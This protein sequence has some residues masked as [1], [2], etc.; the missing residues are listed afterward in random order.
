MYYTH[1]FLYMIYIAH[2]KSLWW[3]YFSAMKCLSCTLP[4]SSGSP[5]PDAPASVLHVQ[6]NT[7]PD[8]RPCL[9]CS[10]I[11]GHITARVNVEK[12]SRLAFGRFSVQNLAGYSSCQESIL[13]GFLPPKYFPINQ[14]SYLCMSCQLDI[15]PYN[16]C[17][18]NVTYVGFCICYLVHAGFL[19]D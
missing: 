13:I 1:S 8:K 11:K 5:P 19:F 10:P 16:N 4:F 7:P 9:Q 2:Y 14:S 6:S 3:K 15:A 17:G 18:T 12:G